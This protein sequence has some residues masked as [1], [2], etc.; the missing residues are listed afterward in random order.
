MPKKKKVSAKIP[1]RKP[2]HGWLKV[3]VGV[4][5]LLLIGLLLLPVY[6]KK[7]ILEL[8]DPSADP[9]GA[10]EGDVV[11]IEYVLRLESG[12]V[13]DT[14]NVE[15]AKETGLATYVKGP[16][17]L[18]VGKSGKV[19]GFDDALKGLHAGESRSV[20]ILPSQPVTRVVI[21]KSQEKWRNEPIP[22]VSFLSRTDFEERFSRPP[23]IGDVVVSRDRDIP[24]RLQVKNVSEKRV[25]LAMVVKEGES[26]KLPG[27]PWK[28]TVIGVY[29]HTVT[30]RHNP[31]NGMKV[32]SVF[33]S[34]DVSV[35]ASKYVVR[36]S[37]SVGQLV[38]Y[39]IPADML[40]NEAGLQG[41]V[42]TSPGQE[43][44]FKHVFKVTEVSDDLITIER[45]DNLAEKKLLSEF[46]ILELVKKE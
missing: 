16:Y 24:F 15:L 30:V 33:G 18:I 35:E 40:N 31:E 37:A 28:S 5:V 9:T 12:V 44:T 22:K 29:E 14:N 10:Q 4:G 36:Y 25:A 39:S 23:V 8:P 38:N 46:K 2:V 7:V 42:R 43:L 20:T 1:V 32:D 11:S 17:R 26:I 6:N 41:T 21:N 13:V 3:M 27:L 34:A 19:K 45:D